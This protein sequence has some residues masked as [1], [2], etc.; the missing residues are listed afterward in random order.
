VDDKG[1]FDQD[2]ERAL[3]E[4]NKSAGE[5]PSADVLE[6]YAHGGLAAAEIAAIRRH[7]TGCGICELVVERLRTLDAP[8]WTATEKKLRKGLGIAREA[9]PAWRRILWNP[10]PAYAL[11]AAL[12]I[13]LGV[14]R[15]TPA[16]KPP[17]VPAPQAAITVPMVL[18]FE[19]VTRAGVRAT[20]LPGRGHSDTVLF[21]F[22]VPIQ[23][24]STHSATI[25]GN[26][27]RVIV[28][29]QDIVSQDALGNFYLT[30]DARLIGTGGYVLQVTESG[31]RNR[32]FE[33]PFSM[34]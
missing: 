29:T 31:G 17:S 2:M 12:A 34:P 25:L 32:P 3:H 13:S 22:F 9:K 6:T 18:K 5:C 14:A 20:R 28:P 24:G 10:A 4:L 19:P 26:S 15:R 11:A 7:L 8:D 23:R 33:F 27:G 21:M 30:C 1:G 16:P